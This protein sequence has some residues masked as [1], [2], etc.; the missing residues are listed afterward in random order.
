MATARESCD[1]EEAR[2]RDLE[3]KVSELRTSKKA[4]FK[5]ARPVNVELEKITQHE[6]ECVDELNRL[7]AEK[8]DREQRQ[9]I[10]PRIIELEA[11]LKRVKCRNEAL[12]R[13]KETLKHTNSKCT[14]TIN[15]LKQSL[16]EGART[17]RLQSRKISELNAK[18]SA[19]QQSRS[20]HVLAR[21][22]TKN[23]K[24]VTELQEQLH[25]TNERLCQTE[26]ELNET[27][28]RLSDVQERLTVAKQVTAA[29]QQRELQESDNSEQLQLELTPQH[30][31]TTHASMNLFFQLMRTSV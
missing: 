8:H 18:I 27:R 3:R 22:G 16:H 9:Q 5:K 24:R 30:Q 10:V 6:R 17:S 11:E 1:E 26:D 29:T 20:A 19:L 28:Q 21:L 23:S 15:S 25:E 12:E 2:I 14:V 31:P 13:E 7:R 4:V